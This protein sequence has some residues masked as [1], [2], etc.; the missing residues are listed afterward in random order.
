M[1]LL[2]QKFAIGSRE[3]VLIVLLISATWEVLELYLEIGALAGENIQY[4][5]QGVE[6]PL[7]RIFSDQVLLLLG[8]H[9]A[10]S[11]MRISVLAK[12]A[13]GIWLLWHVFVLPHS[14][15]IQDSWSQALKP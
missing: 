10:R 7:N 1:G 13:A 5:F 2:S 6:H 4:W 11:N 12:I 9:F 15:Y 3:K 14:M 8:Y